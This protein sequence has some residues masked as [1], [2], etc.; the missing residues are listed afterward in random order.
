MGIKNQQEIT[1]SNHNALPTEA[2]LITGKTTGWVVGSNGLRELTVSYCE[3]PRNSARVI[4]EIHYLSKYRCCQTG[5]TLRQF[6]L[7]VGG[8]VGLY[9][10]CLFA[11]ILATSKAICSSGNSINKLFFI[12]QKSQRRVSGKQFCSCTVIYVMIVKIC[13]APENVNAL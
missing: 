12:P 5:L 7:H 9:C 6:C 3:L 10:Q 2:S 11:L 8:S 1:T 4:W 13:S